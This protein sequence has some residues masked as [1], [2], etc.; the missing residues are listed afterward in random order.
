MNNLQSLGPEMMNPSSQVLMHSAFYSYL[1]GI[2]VPFTIIA[3]T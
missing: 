2:R 1:I 3:V